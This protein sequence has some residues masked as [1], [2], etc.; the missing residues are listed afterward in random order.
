MNINMKLGNANGRDGVNRPESRNCASME[1]RTRALS[2]VY[3]HNIRKCLSF[4]PRQDCWS[5][6]ERK[7]VRLVSVA[8]HSG[9]VC[10]WGSE[11]VRLQH[12]TLCNSYVDLSEC[13]R[14]VKIGE[15]VPNDWP[16]N[17]WFSPCSI[18]LEFLNNTDVGE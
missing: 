16:L 17:S 10:L 8:P 15:T 13:S 6:F 12:V 4:I 3:L 1:Q 9:L 2:Q 5:T 11:T 18:F 14:V 7:F